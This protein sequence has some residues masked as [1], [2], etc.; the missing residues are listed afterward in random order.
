MIFVLWAIFG[1]IAGAVYFFGYNAFE[2]RNYRDTQKHNLDLSKASA[3]AI[4]I[5][6]C[7]GNL[8]TI[9]IYEVIFCV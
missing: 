9:F 5:G 8:V 7:L 3:I 2:Y 4:F 1:A 6:L